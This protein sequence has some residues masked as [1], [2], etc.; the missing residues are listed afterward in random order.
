VNPW[1]PVLIGIGIILIV[2]GFKGSQH[3]VLKAFKGIKTR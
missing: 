2:M 1:A 3:N